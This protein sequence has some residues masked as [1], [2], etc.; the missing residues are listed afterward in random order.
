MYC[1]FFPTFLVE[2]NATFQL[3]VS[4]V[5]FIPIQVYGPFEIYPRTPQRSVDPRLRTPAL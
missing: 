2:G 1:G 4:D 3:E 5:I